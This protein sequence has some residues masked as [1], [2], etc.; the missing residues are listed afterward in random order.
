[1][2]EAGAAGTTV[3]VVDDEVLVGLDMK[4]SLEESGYTVMGPFTDPVSAVAALDESSPD[5]AILDA[6]LDGRSSGPVAERLLELAVPFIYVTGYG[7]DFARGQLPPAEALG[8]PVRM[9]DLV[10]RVRAA[11]GDGA[12]KGKLA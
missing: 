3:M 12:P 4:M 1:M 9:S 2:K 11:L 6:N 7:E 5:F 8:K 10:K